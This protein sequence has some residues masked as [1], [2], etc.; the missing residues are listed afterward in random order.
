MFPSQPLD[1]NDEDSPRVLPVR[2][3][4]LYVAVETYL[5]PAAPDLT[6][7]PGT[8]LI[9]SDAY[10]Y[11]GNVAGK[12]AD[13]T[14]HSCPVRFSL[15][16]PDEEGFFRVGGTQYLIPIVGLPDPWQPLLFGKYHFLSRDQV[17]L[18]LLENA[19]ERVFSD[20]FYNSRPGETCQ[21]NL[22]SLQTSLL[23]RITQHAGD[24]LGWLRQ[25]GDSPVKK[26]AFRDTVILH[27]RRS[28][29]RAESR[30]FPEEMLGALD[31]T[32]TPTSEK[33][34]ITF[35]GCEGFKVED[36]QIKK[37]VSSLCAFTNRVG[38]MTMENPKRAHLIRTSA[39][40]SLPLMKPSVK[41]VGHKESPVDI[42][43]LNTAFMSLGP[44]TFE[45]MIAVSETGAKKLEAM[46]HSTVVCWFSKRP[47][48][49]VEQG[50]FLRGGERIAEVDRDAMVF[51]NALT[52][53]DDDKFRILAPDCGFTTSLEGVNVCAHWHLGTLGVRVVWK[54]TSYLPLETGDKIVD[55]SCC[56]GVVKVLPDQEMPW[57]RSGEVVDAC[58]SPD[59]PARRH[60]VSMLHEA[61]INKMVIKDGVSIHARAD[62]IPVPFDTLVKRGYGSGTRLVYRGKSLKFPT[63]LAPIGW[64]RVDKIAKDIES[65][66]GSERPLT[67]EGLP[68]DR[69]SLA[70]QSC[71]P[72]KGLALR[73]RGLVH[74]HSSLLGEGKGIGI[75][76]ELVE[77]IEGPARD[78]R[79]TKEDR[80]EP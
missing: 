30:A 48:L 66:V 78:F 63:T 61:M 3:Y 40:N 45:D 28:W 34:N 8:Q 24:S 35:Q 68:V 9:Q 33:I 39:M 73:N 37:G 52:E 1:P 79:Q 12:C 80:V 71:D 14:L 49:L 54:L 32:S 57:T 62:E 27:P 55:R 77:A 58:V 67:A 47:T 29:R 70:G 50:S 17:A 25:V 2:P 44:H 26:A 4:G 21:V 11:V 6:D 16:R 43:Y 5:P 13:G 75:V 20:F 19:F 15:P 72:S 65:A 18:R 7:I 22:T 59:S 53:E 46:K 41:L 38:L 51:G 60:A 10:F 69:A 42:A 36:G 64:M 74:T 56:K 23:S 76:A 31:P